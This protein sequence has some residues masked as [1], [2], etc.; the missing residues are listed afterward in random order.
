MRKKILVPTDFSKNALYAAQ[1][2]CQIANK[3]NYDIHLFH[4]YTTSTAIEIENSTNL[5]ADILIEE[6]KQHLKKSFPSIEIETECVSRLLVDVLPDYATADKFAFIVM[7]TTGAGQGK[8]LIWG[9]NT[10]LISSKV[11]IPVIAIPAK[12][13]SFSS[14]KI[15]ILT[16]F[17]AEELETLN[18]YITY[19]SPIKNLDI[20]HIYKDNNK[21]KEIEQQLTDWTFNIKQLS[22]ID[23]VNIIAQPI[24]HDNDSLDTIPEV[25]NHI[26]LENDYDIILVTKTRKSFF[27]RII[28]TSVS[29]EI[30]LTLQKPTFFDN[31]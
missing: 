4:C 30:T 19:I 9:S 26:I 6:V 18:N 7:G 27:E 29:R 23:Y 2:A 28:S 5:K 14:D 24:Q 31:I 3:S 13:L 15:A 22:D 12:E 17:K 11:K 25:I 1:Y 16:N 21:I 10:S 20:I 8:P